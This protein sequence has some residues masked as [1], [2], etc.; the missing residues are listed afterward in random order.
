MHPLRVYLCDLTH[1]AVILVSDTIPINI[2][3]IGAYAKKEHGALIDISLFKYP[4]SAIEAIKKDPPDVLALSNYSWNSLL[5]EKIASI[6]KS[7]N[8]E[9]ITIQGGPNFPHASDLQYE[10]LKKRPSTNFHIMFEGEA[11]FSNVIDR[12]LKFRKNEEEL[13]EQP[14][15]GAVFIHP[16]K[17]KGLIKGTKAQDRIKFLD[18]IPSPYLN[19]MLDKFFDGRLSPFIETNRGCPYQCSFCDWGN[20]TLGKVKKFDLDRVKKEILWF[21]KNKVEFIVNCDANFGIFKD[22]DYELTNFMCKLKK[23]YGYPVTFDT[24][25]PKDNNSKS[26]EIAKLLLDHK[27]SLCL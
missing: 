23:R 2:G 5:S 27:S 6:A 18:D 14:I 9:V 20:G 22:R 24:N 26:V 4:N 1:D 17:E 10:Y 13:W 11:S 19:G 25:W 16:N 7:I 12:I 21:A 3:Y 8:P 15:N